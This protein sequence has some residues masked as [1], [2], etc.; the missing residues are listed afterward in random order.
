MRF[1]PTG[2]PW[3]ASSARRSAWRCRPHRNRNEVR[4]TRDRCPNPFWAHA[5]RSLRG[6]PLKPEFL[7][8][9]G[10]HRRVARKLLYELKALFFKIGRKITYWVGSHHVFPF[11][12]PKHNEPGVCQF[13]IGRL[14]AAP[15]T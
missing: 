12:S 14:T 10:R 9:I 4:L 7:H 13:R 15:S 2:K 1:T 8:R 6:Q 11:R 3:S 5:L